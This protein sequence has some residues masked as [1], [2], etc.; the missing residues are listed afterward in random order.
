MK[1]LLRTAALAFLCHFAANSQQFH[2]TDHWNNPGLTMV[3]S[4]PGK[5]EL[6]Y[7]ISEWSLSDLAIGRENLKK[8]ELPGNFLPNDEGAPD[9]PGSGQL[10]AVPQGAAPR[11]SILALETETLTGID[12]APAPRIPKTTENGPLFYAKNQE[13]YSA[14]A[15]YPENPVRLS[16]VTQ[17]RGLDV[18]MLGVTPFQYN[19][20]RRELVVIRNIQIEVTFEG[21]NGQFGD[22]RL[23]SRYW[24]P[25]LKDAVAN[26]AQILPVDFASRQWAVGSWQ[27]GVRETGFEYLIICPDDPVFTAWADTIRLFRGK[28]GI[29]T[30][31]VTT[32]EIGGN[33]VAAIESYVN[34]AYNTWDIPPAAVL[35]LG[36]YGTSGAT[37][38]API[39]DNYCASDNIYAD[40][41]G[42]QLPDIVFSRMTAQNATHLETMIR[43]F[44]DYETNPPTDPDYYDHPITALGWQTERWFQVC[45]EVV[46]GFFRNELGKDPIRINEVYDGNPSVDPWSTAPNTNTI[47]NYFGPNGLD[48]IPSSPSALGDWSGG[49]ATDINNAINSGS[50]MLLHRDHGYEL[51]WGEPA[52]SN[53]SMSG[54]NNDNLTFVWSVN[55]LTGKY[56]YGSECFAEAFHRRPKRAL[57]LIA[58]SEVSYSFV[59]DTYVWGAFD[60]LWPEFMPS[61]GS[62]PEPRGLLPSFGNAAGKIFLQ[63]SSWPYNTGNKVVTYH[64]FHHHGDAFSTLYSEVPQQ[65][66]INHDGVMTA[67]SD[68][69]TVQADEG[70]L[71]ALSVNGEIIGLADGTGALAAVPI[72]PQI[73]GADVRLVVTK[74]NHFRYE[75]AVTVISPNAPYVICQGHALNDAAGNGDGLMDYAESC[76]LSVTVNNLGTIDAENAMVSVST[77]TPFITFT[78]ST[79]P[80]G[81]IAGNGEITLAD[82]FAFMVADSL[83][84]GYIVDFLVEVTADNGSWTSQFN[85][86]GHAPVLELIDYQVDDSNGDDNGRIDPGE[87]AGLLVTISNT[88]SSAA[89]SLET[90]LTTNNGYITVLMPAQSTLQLDPGETI[91]LP[92]Q[93]SADE[94]TPGGTTAEFNVSITAEHDRNGMGT[95]STIIGQFA[96]LILD[97]DP[98]TH[99]APAM[100]EAFADMDLVAEYQ[101]TFPDDFS[102][103]KS[104]FVC[105]GIYYSYHELTESEAI[106]LSRY[107]S[108]GGNLYLEGRSVWYDDEQTSIQ[109][110][111]NITSEFTNWYQYD[112]IFAPGGV[113]T[114]GMM[115]D[116][117]GSNPFNNHI[118]HAAE[119][120]FLLFGNQP[121][122]MGTMVAYDAATYKTVGA[123][124]EF[125]ALADGESPSTKAMLMERILEFFGDI[126]TGVPNENPAQGMHHVSVYPNPSSGNF[127]FAWTLDHP[128]QVNLEIYDLSGR[129]VFRASDKVFSKGYHELEWNVPQ[130]SETMRGGM[131]FY[132]ISSSG[133]VQTGK[134]LLSR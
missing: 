66:A 81:T 17:I 72:V 122:S 132:R 12:L 7:S 18:V 84:D 25:L 101:T 21:G 31:V 107:L 40:V 42:N 128:S 39:W 130:D 74:T 44:I 4:T 94:S 1:H 91:T 69:Y 70:A 127:R 102:I 38:V 67:G 116:Y 103:Y 36:D 113:F 57:G 2:Y 117:S 79:E 104:V 56:N 29:S 124:M 28:Q 93:V 78:D 32:T 16:E 77:T 8:V 96:A 73:P 43:K 92:Y 123:N 41:T 133:G 126:L 99:S 27:S 30:G 64:L 97:L 108:E 131:Y 105:L 86:E 125:G 58:A 62:N 24:D 98:N 106:T 61:Y 87:T 89:F 109:P 46:G 110:M 63:Q 52:Y 112:S 129:M 68:T 76:L 48:Y 111:F 54:L 55:C 23:R 50:F 19:P 83:P 95:F 45:I 51:G 15:L 82:G 134:L 100:M 10:I 80:A 34:N 53:S 37:V 121:D 47:M 65:L 22:D 35:I 90:A 88:G 26:A 14:D 115:F 114:E 119:P 75:S 33:T 11:L 13:I 9:L 118:L 120:A 49:N 20:V 60:N 85:V 3:S 59:N 5:V 6:T 71:I